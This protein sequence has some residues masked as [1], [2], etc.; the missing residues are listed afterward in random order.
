MSVARKFY[1]VPPEMVRSDRGP[2]NP[3][4]LNAINSY[5]RQATSALEDA[6]LP[7]DVRLKLYENAKNRQRAYERKAYPFYENQ[8]VVS[9]ASKPTPA[10]APS[11]GRDPID[12]LGTVPKTY[13]TQ[14][15]WLLDKV[16]RSEHMR[17]HPETGRLIVNGEDVPDS[18]IADLINDLVRVRKTKARPA[19]WETFNEAL[20]RD[21][22]IPKTVLANEGRARRRDYIKAKPGWRSSV[23]ARGFVDSSPPTASSSRKRVPSSSPIGRRTRARKKDRSWSWSQST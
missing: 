20:F 11:K 6:S 22:D 2:R 13:R 3:P 16:K 17:V 1:L 4:I 7:D 14:A 18:H 23:K 9:P 5:Q 21:G 19:G 15:S 12:V 10:P 8:A